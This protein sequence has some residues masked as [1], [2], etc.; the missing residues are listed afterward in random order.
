MNEYK[1]MYFLF[2]DLLLFPISQQSIWSEI[3]SHNPLHG[4]V[5]SLSRYTKA[6]VGLARQSWNKNVI[7]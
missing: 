2:Y 5:S 6:H 3:T 1:T 4:S 7:P